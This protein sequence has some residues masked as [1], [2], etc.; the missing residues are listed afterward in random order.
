MGWERALLYKE[1]GLWTLQLFEGSVG[2][3]WNKATCWRSYQNAPPAE[4]GSKEETVPYF[5]RQTSEVFGCHGKQHRWDGDFAIWPGALV[6]KLDHACGKYSVTI[7]FQVALMFGVVQ[8]YLHLPGL[9]WLRSQQSWASRLHA[10]DFKKML[11]TL[12]QCK[13]VSS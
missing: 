7:A 1:V 2:D 4:N 10:I 9:G 6:K 8:T 3:G 12:I 13:I 11:W 5:W